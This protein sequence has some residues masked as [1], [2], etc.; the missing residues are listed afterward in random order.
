[1]QFNFYGQYKAYTN[2]Q[3]LEILLHE[4]DYQEDAITAARQ[5]L[6]EREVNITEALAALAI[7]LAQVPPVVTATVNKLTVP[8]GEDLLAEIQ[9]EVDSP[10]SNFRWHLPF[11]ILMTI[12]YA[13]IALGSLSNLSSYYECTSCHFD[14]YTAFSLASLIWAVLILIFLYTRKRRAWMFILSYTIFSSITSLISIYSILRYSGTFSAL[15]VSNFISIILHGL[16]IYWMLRPSTTTA[17]NI[18]ANVQKDTLMTSLL[19]CAI[20]IGAL[21][22]K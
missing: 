5:L 21:L 3:L 14:F 4:N 19:L 15:T 16:F 13:L 9:K 10:K 8:H 1:M 22:M 17:F 18:D 12:L 6:I 11:T 2:N 7:P 20:Y